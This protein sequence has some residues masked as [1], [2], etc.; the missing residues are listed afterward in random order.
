MRI[1]EIHRDEYD[2]MK[3]LVLE[4]FMQFEAP[5]YRPQGIETFK[6]TGIENDAYMASLT[7]Y[8]AYIGN[9]LVGVIATRNEGK[10]IALFFVK[11][12]CHRQ[13]IGKALFERVKQDGM[14]VNCI[15]L[16]K[17]DS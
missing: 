7:V 4:V 14:T 3:S 6:R 1:R 13:G 10:H 15:P 8:G 5:D 11:G 12:A 9:K 17:V 2:A 16:K